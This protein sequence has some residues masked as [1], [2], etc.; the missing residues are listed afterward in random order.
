M[1]TFWYY[2]RLRSMCLGEII[3]RTRH[4]C[5][6]IIARLMRKIWAVKYQRNSADAVSLLDT[7]G[8]VC[9][10]G[11]NNIKPADVPD[12]WIRNTIATAE[13]LLQHRCK[14]FALE[15]VYWGE[16]I[17]WNHEYKRNIDTPLIFGPWMNYRD[18]ES[19]GD[20]KYFWELPRLQH[21][22]TLAKAYYLTNNEK[23][24]NAVVEQ[25]NDFVE[26]CPY[27]LGVN[28]KCPMDSAIRAINFIWALQLSATEKNIAVYKKIV[29]SLYDHV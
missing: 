5:W 18:T 19:Y 1:K 7:F 28:W 29:C 17:N 25:L 22:I 20:F 9:F 27:L 21:L 24:A 16:R 14:L 15:D 12:S 3:W 2:H 13:K 26:Q 11:L 23:Y 6:Q 8:Q 10:Y 4:L